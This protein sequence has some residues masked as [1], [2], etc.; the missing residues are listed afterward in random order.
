MQSGNRAS[1]AVWLW[2]A[3]GLLG[4]FVLPWYLLEDGFFSFEWLF[5]G[6]PIDSDYAPAVFLVA[7]GEKVWLAPLILPLLLP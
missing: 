1:R 6:Y 2:M 3:V 7:Q 4:Y 5:D